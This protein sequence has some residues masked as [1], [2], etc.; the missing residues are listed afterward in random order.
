MQ[1]RACLLWRARRLLLRA[2]PHRGGLPRNGASHI[3]RDAPPF[4]PP[5]QLRNV[6]EFDGGVTDTYLHPA[7]GGVDTW[8]VITRGTPAR[9]RVPPGSTPQPRVPTQATPERAFDIKYFPR[10]VRRNR[11][12]S[13]FFPIEASLSAESQKLLITPSSGRWGAVGPVD[14]AVPPP[15]SNTGMKNPD[16]A[17][18]DPAGLRTTMTSNLAAMNKSLAAHR[19]NHLPREGVPRPG[20]KRQRNAMAIAQWGSW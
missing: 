1:R 11:D 3:F 12:P 16:V 13:S 20:V 15:G 17:R 8:N 6:L 19:P 9:Y 10:D 14:P 2:A 18:Y 4:S 7:K 5:L